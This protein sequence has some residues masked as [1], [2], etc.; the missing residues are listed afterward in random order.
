MNKDLVQ[1]TAWFIGLWVAGVAAVALVGL[2][3]RTFLM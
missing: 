2:V 1:K 3:I